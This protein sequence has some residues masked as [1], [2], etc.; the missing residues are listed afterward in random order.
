MEGM[1][2]KWSLLLS[3]LFFGGALFFVSCSKAPPPAQGPVSFDWDKGPIEI[4]AAVA[5]Y[6]KDMQKD[7]NDV[8]KAKCTQCHPLSRAIW[9]PYTDEATWTKIVN[10]MATRPGSQVSTE[11]VGALVKFL[12]YDHTQR[13]ADIEKMFQDN[14]WEKKD[15]V[16]L[17]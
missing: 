2:M 3:A 17:Q 4:D 6:P 11:E 13:K 14:H 15:P 5:K 16:G 7:Y 10:R 12:V 9:A 8:F 1:S